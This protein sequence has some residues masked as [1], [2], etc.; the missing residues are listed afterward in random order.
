MNKEQPTMNQ[1]KP[2]IDEQV[3]ETVFNEILEDLRKVTRSNQALQTTVQDL[4]ARLDTFATKLNELQV[5]VPPV[6]QQPLH[7][8]AREGIDKIRQTLQSDVQ[9][10]LEAGIQKI[11]AIIGAQPKT[12]IQ[13]RH[14]F[15]FPKN[16]HEGHYKFLI[17]WIVGLILGLASLG[18]LSNWLQSV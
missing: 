7:H 14:F 18:V 3:F 12:V 15:L 17:R 4:G 16:D 2:A 10:P 11:T 6:D 13:E 9:Q 5:I 8:I 1:Q